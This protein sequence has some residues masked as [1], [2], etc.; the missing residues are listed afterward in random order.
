MTSLLIRSRCIALAVLGL[1][2]LAACNA[3]EDVREEPSIPLPV[4][5]VALQGIVTGLGSERSLGLKNNGSLSDAVSV[6][7]PTPL[8]VS[9]TGGIAPVAFSFGARAVR[10][11]NGNPVPYNIE[12]NGVPYGKVCAFRA[13]TP[14]SGVLS[15]ESPPNIL[16]DCTPAPGLQLYDVVVNLRRHLPMHRAQQCGSPPKRP[17][18]SRR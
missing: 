8:E 17:F 10:D 7:A 1:A 4:P 2:G 11:A 13:D 5:T 6:Q 18:T 3:V 9:T 14:H 16:I 12:F 15:V